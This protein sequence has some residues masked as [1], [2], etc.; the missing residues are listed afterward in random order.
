MHFARK[1]GY[2][3]Q[4]LLEYVHTYIEVQHI[5]QK[6]SLYNSNKFRRQCLL[7]PPLCSHA[8]GLVVVP[9][10]S[11]SRIWGR[12]FSSQTPLLWS[13]IP[14]CILE[15]DT[16]TK[17][18]VSLS[19]KTAGIGSSD[20][21]RPWKRKRMDGWL[22]YGAIGSDFMEGTEHFLSIHLFSLLRCLYPTAAC[23]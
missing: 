22:S 6:Q 19:P 2:R 21:P 10:I 11:R 1:M 13:Q 17:F 8:A 15:T 23:P 12:A 4:H 5:K 3:C 20:P 16:L 18:K 7:W 9:R 14:V